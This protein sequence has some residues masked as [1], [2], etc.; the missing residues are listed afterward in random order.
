MPNY[1]SL[2]ASAVFAALGDP[3]RRAV[4]QK[5]TE[6]DAPVGAL[7]APHD[8]ALPTFLQHLRVLEAA[9]LITT[10]KVGRTRICSLQPGG[11]DA[12]TAWLREI[13]AGWER[14]L[15]HLARHLHEEGENP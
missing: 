6:G 3:T 4:L 2:D 5:L 14:R 11:L 7:V 15:D 8:M 10:R 1:S 9:N 12:A 13:E